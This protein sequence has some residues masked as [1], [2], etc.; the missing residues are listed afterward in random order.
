[1]CKESRDEWEMKFNELYIQPII[2]NID[3]VLKNTQEL[4]VNDDSQGKQKTICETI[5]QYTDDT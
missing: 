4:I 5:T 1:M 2:S 3:S